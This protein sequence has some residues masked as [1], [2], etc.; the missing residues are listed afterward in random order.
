MPRPARRLLPLLCAAALVA[1][2][3]F[4]Q[5][6]AHGAQPLTSAQVPLPADVG[7]PGTLAIAVDATDP[8]PRIVPIREATPA[9]PGRLTQLYPQ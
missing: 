6:G 9:Q 1:M 4:A 7:Y 8:A 3:V 5:T 2:P